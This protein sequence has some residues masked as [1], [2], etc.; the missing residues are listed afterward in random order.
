LQNITDALSSHFLAEPRSTI[1]LSNLLDI[2][3]LLGRSDGETSNHL[4]MEHLEGG[5]K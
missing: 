4:K 5:Y 3:H 2:D 1:S